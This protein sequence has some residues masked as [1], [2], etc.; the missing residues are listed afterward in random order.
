M[1]TIT[2]RGKVIVGQFSKVS[3][4]RVREMRNSDGEFLGFIEK[5]DE[6]GYRVIRKDGRSGLSHC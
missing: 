5:L 1:S 6:G 3:G 2:V 4:S